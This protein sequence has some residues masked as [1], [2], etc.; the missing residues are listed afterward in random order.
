MTLD[1]ATR[2]EIIAA[3]AERLHQDFRAGQASGLDDIIVVPMP[4][5]TQALGLGAR[6][7][8]RRLPVTR[9]GDRTHGVRLS[10]LKAHLDANTTQPK[11]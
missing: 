4:M 10:A 7:I 3:L 6:M 2:S 8:A 1:P 9:I 5:V 11:P